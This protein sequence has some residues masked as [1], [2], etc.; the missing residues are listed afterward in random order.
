MEEE[1]PGRKFVELSPSVIQKAE[2]ADFELGYLAKEISKKIIKGTT[3]F[4]LVAY[5]KMQEEREN[6]GR[7]VKEEGTRNRGSVI[8]ELTTFICDFGLLVDAEN[9]MREPQEE[10]NVFCIL[11]RENLWKPE[12]RLQ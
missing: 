3:W 6:E 4:L 9:G 1:N 7:I 12:G 5:S 11:D 8:F 10:A 2:F